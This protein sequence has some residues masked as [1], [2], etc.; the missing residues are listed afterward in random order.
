MADNSPICSP[1]GRPPLCRPPLPPGDCCWKQAGKV[2][3]TCVF[4]VAARHCPPDLARQLRARGAA[5]WNLYGPTETTIWSLSQPVQSVEQAIPIGRPIANTQVYVL[6][7]Q[8]QPVPIGVPGDL[9]IGGA[10]LARGYL[11]RPDLTAERFLPDPF[12]SEPGQRLYHTGDRARYLPDGIVEFLGRTDQ[13]I[14]LRGYRI[15]LGEIE[16]VL[17]QH[18]AFVRV[19]LLYAKMSMVILVW[20]LTSWRTKG[21]RLLT[22][23]HQALSHG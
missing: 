5:L 11:H 6:D 22:T 23:G 4:S 21:L 17:A 12:S 7:A 18:P 19:L 14:K 15:E 20:W 9:Y 10:G 13:Q 1:P 2:I 8:W 16:A 3:H